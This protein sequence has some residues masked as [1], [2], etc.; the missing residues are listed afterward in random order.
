MLG[1]E[2]CH[3]S[4]RRKAPIRQYCQW[5]ST[6][7]ALEQ[8]SREIGILCSP[9]SSSHFPGTWTS[10]TRGRPAVVHQ[11]SPA[12]G[13]SANANY[14]NTSASCE[15]F[16]E[17]SSMSLWC[18]L[19]AIIDYYRLPSDV[20]DTSYS[21]KVSPITR[22]SKIVENTHK[23]FSSSGLVNATVIIVFASWK[24]TSSIMNGR[25]G[26][27]PNMLA[28]RRLIPYFTCAKMQWRNWYII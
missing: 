19:A 21:F 13:R 17:R 6:S 23:S 28:A 2:S 15:L 25:K 11:N 14:C 24:S 10:S 9:P 3:S 5:T 8:R 1:T 4:E 16:G 12:R 7:V 26:L 22:K 20:T 18:L 27:C